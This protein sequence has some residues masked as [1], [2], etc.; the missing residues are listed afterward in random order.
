MLEIPCSRRGWGVAMTKGLVSGTFGEDP[1]LWRKSKGS[2]ATW[3][4]AE[5][6][7]YI[8]IHF[9]ITLSSQNLPGCPQD[10]GGI[11]RPKE[12]TRKQGFDG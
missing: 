12:L 1:I 6:V 8:L 10:E 2:C 3:L 9:C 4:A 11:V 7:D 5:C